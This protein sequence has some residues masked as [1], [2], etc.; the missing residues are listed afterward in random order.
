MTTAYEHE[1]A[2]VCAL[3]RQVALRLYR[4]DFATHAAPDGEKIRQAANKIAET[5]KLLD[6]RPPEDDEDEFQA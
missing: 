6:Q 1:K 4:L 2:E 3:L 5:L